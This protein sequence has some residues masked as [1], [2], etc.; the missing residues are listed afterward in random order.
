QRDGVARFESIDDWVRTDIRGWTL[1][2]SIDDEQLAELQQEARTA[3]ADFVDS[4]GRVTFQ[5]PAL[6]ATARRA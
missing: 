6:I 1:A 5:A 4:D 2:G 3:L